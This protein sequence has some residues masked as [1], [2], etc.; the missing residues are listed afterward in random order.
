MKPT[1]AGRIA[2]EVAATERLDSRRRPTTNAAAIAS[3][4][5]TARITSS[6][7]IACQ[8]VRFFPSAAYHGR[9]SATSIA[10]PPTA[11]SQS[12][13]L[14]RRRFTARRL[15]DSCA[16]FGRLQPSRLHRVREQHRDRH[17]A[18]AAGHRRDRGGL[19]SH[20]LEVDVT[21]ETVLG[22]IRADVDHDDALANHLCRDELRPPDGGNE[23]VRP[24]ADL[25]EVAR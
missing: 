25:R 16:A 11:A 21:D 1:T 6:S 9:N 18:D 24:A 4:A 15:T 22:A 8:A 2:S 23:H 20:R 17:R 12:P 3:A 19:L 13:G 14:R 10:T 5:A 7:A